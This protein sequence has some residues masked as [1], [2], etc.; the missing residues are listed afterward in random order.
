MS[1]FLKEISELN[2]EVTLCLE[3]GRLLTGR[4][5]GVDTT[6]TPVGVLLFE[7]NDK[8]YELGD[9]DIADYAVV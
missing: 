1:W 7:V 5:I 3:D 9:R 2:S 8:K 6:S 4:A